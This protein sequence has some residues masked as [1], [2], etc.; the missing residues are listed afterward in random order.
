MK[1]YIIPTTNLQEDAMIELAELRKLQNLSSDLDE[2]VMYEAGLEENSHMSAT[3]IVT[4]CML[5]I[6][7][8]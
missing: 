4:L 1:S 8:F 3:E 6:E 7:V 5:L 2:M